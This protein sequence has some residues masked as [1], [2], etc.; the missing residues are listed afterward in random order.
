MPALP[1]VTVVS[2]AERPDLIRA[3]HDVYSECL[4][5]MP[6]PTP[7]RAEPFHEW[8]SQTLEGPATL[9]EAAMVAL[10]GEAVI[11]QAALTLEG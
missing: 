4:P 3:A 8:V 11:G 5:D 10:A 7:M 2:L 6:S 9:T 1:G